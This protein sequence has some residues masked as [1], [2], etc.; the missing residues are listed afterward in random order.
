MVNKVVATLAVAGLAVIPAT[1]ILTTASSARATN[2]YTIRSNLCYQ[3]SGSS[4]TGGVSHE[5]DAYIPNGLTQ[6]T[7]GVIL[8]HGGGFSSGSKANMAS[9]ARSL[10]GDGMA[11]FSINY[12]LDSATT[13]GYPMQIQDVMAAV[14]FI[15]AHAGSYNV[16]ASRLA[17]FGSS[18]GA[19]LA[20]DSG[21]EAYQNKPSARVKA[22]VGWSGGYDFISAFQQGAIDPAQLANGEHYLGCSDPTVPSCMATAEAASATSW[23]KAG[24]PATLLANSTDY[25]VGCEIVDPAQAEEM[26]SDL[27]NVGSPVTLDLNS[28]C[29][30]ATAYS[31]VELPNTTAFLEANLFIAPV[32]TSPSSK[33]LTVGTASTFKITSKGNPVATISE[34][35]ALPSGMKFASGAAGT[36]TISGTPRAGTVGT[37]DL[38]ITAQ[39]GGSPNG[40]QHLVLEVAE[41]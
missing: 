14:T 15:R 41:N 34:A 19:T 7:P 23:V 27:Q 29:A 13:P 4:C 16:D 40:V 21:V 30:H 36:A 37:Y 28:E 17:L 22:L 6:K 9:I 3:P 18:A 11:A 32:I 2:A 25:K 5:M 38:T 26:A 24:D 20:V 39:N 33:A 1:L 10:A 31:N 12:R 8:V 35:G